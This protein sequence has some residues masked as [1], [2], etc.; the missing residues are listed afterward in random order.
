MVGVQNGM[1][2]FVVGGLSNSMF[3]FHVPVEDNGTSMCKESDV[4]MNKIEI[5]GADDL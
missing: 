2:V 5:I 3:I 1:A 4:L